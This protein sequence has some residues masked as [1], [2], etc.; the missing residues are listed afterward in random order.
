LDR[1]MPFLVRALPQAAHADPIYAMEVLALDQERIKTL[2]GVPALTAFFFE[3]Q[4][5]YDSALL[6]SKNLDTARAIAALD[7]LL[8]VLREQDDWT[9]DTLL[10]AL[11]G[12]VVANGFVRKKADGSEVPDRGPIF[13]LVRVAVS[14]RKETPG[15]PEM[16]VILGKERV[17]ARL[18]AAR[19]KLERFAATTK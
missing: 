10:A 11:D 2:A 14:G 4:P 13:M 8:P 17:L 12:F 9:H 6:L 3:D 19:D 1:A 18:G 15:L 7:A 5:D 16:L